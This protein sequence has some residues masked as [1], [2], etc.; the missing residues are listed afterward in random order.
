MTI[1]ELAEFAGVDARLVYIWVLRDRL[2]VRLPRGDTKHSGRAHKYD[3]APWDVARW[4]AK[5]Q[6]NYPTLDPHWPANMIG[7]MMF[8]KR[9]RRG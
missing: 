8:D 2:P 4:W 1:D 9:D 5:F 7:S 3:I 6:T